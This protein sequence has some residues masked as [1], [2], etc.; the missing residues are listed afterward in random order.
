VIVLENGKITRQGKA[1]LAIEIE[2]KGYGNN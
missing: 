2:D 1:N